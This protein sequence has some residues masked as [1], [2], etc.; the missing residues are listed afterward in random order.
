[1]NFLASRSIVTTWTPAALPARYAATAVGLCLYLITVAAVH[2]EDGKDPMVS[3]GKGTT[4]QNRHSRV[5]SSTNLD[6][7]TAEII[8]RSN[9]LALAAGYG[10]ANLPSV[11]DYQTWRRANRLPYR[12]YSHGRR[13]LNNY[14]NEK[15]EDYLKYENVERLPEGAIIAKNS[16]SVTDKGE[17]KPGPLFIMEKMARGFNYLSGDWR[18]TTVSP[19]GTVVG[20]TKGMN[21]SRVEFCIKCH[22]AAEKR[23]HLFFFPK[24]FR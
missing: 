10:R 22:L 16:F 19:D 4:T 20:R 11:A 17:F 1:M 18:Y 21:G 12:S 13:F 23:D 9:K 2:A 15:A 8:Y 6:T 3:P 7:K 14:I 5:E 24:E